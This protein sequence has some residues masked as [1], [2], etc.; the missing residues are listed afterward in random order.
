MAIRFRRWGVNLALWALCLSIA[1]V[2]IACAHVWTVYTAPIGGFYSSMHYTSGAI[3]HADAKGMMFVM[4]IEGGN[5]EEIG[6][7]Y[8]TVGY[9]GHGRLPAPFERRCCD[10][11]PSGNRRG[12]VVGSVLANQIAART[13]IT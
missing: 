10:I 5:T 13:A 6:R 1:L 12:E 4:T 11:G 7:A 8:L 9:Q 3:V 2:V